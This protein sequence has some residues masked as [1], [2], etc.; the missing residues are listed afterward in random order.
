LLAE[1]VTWITTAE[2]ARRLGIKPSQVPDSLERARAAGRMR[3]ITKGAW[4]VV[5]PEYLRWGAPP[6]EHYV[7]AWMRHLGHPYYV[8]LLAAAARHG[9][10]HHAPQVFHVVTAARLRHR[11]IGRS[12]IEF[13]YA[14]RCRE[15]QTVHQTVPTGKLVLSSIAVTLLDLV[16]YPARSGGPSNVASIA[17]LALDEKRLDISAVAANASTF[18]APTV[19]RLGFILTRAMSHVGTTIDLAPLARLVERRPIV[20]LDTRSPATG[21]LDTRWQVRVN[22]DVEIDT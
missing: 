8:G 1:G 10:T 3:S 11:T 7:D 18:R 2:V 14:A 12:K 15:R 20:P 21:A 19:Q 17:A 22:V 9:I 6:P 4:L 5:P 16:A 13:V